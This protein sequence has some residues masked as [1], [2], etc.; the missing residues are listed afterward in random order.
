MGLFVTSEIPATPALKNQLN[1]FELCERKKEKN[2]ISNQL[3]H[4]N[5]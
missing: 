5:D 1:K 4:Y 3:L 2:I